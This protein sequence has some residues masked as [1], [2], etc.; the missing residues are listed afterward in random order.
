VNPYHAH[1]LSCV[2]DGLLNDEHREDLR[3]SMNDT[4][5]AAQ[6]FRSVPPDMINRVLG[7]AAPKVRS[8]YLLPFPDPRGGWMDHVRLKIF[9][10]FHDARGRSVKYL[11]PREA[12]P[13]LF[14][15]I[16]TLAVALE[17]E[18]TLWLLEG[19]KKACSA[20]QLGLPA[21][22]FEGIEG[23]H[24]RGSQQLLADF[25]L[26]PLAGRRVKLVPDGDVQTNPA[27]ERGAVRLAEALERRGARVQI[28]LLLASAA[29]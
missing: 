10:S 24:V 5:I 27:V 7:Y 9:P 18:A 20:A 21:V 12:S 25:D 4:M 16:P 8:A 23:W 2:Y 1:L 14:F 22:G 3:R 13:R 6:R 15:A 11:G 17:A 26:I 29:A 28:V 19:A